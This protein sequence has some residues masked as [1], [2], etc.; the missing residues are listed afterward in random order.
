MVAA[1]RRLRFAGTLALASTSAFR[2]FSAFSSVNKLEATPA[3]E[4]RS[5]ISPSFVLGEYAP[6]ANLN[7]QLLHSQIPTDMRPTAIT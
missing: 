7:P 2:A 1:L 5:A 3:L 6:P 4:A